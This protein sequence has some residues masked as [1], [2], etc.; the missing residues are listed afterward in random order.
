MSTVALGVPC[1]VI[2][3]RGMTANGLGK[4]IWTLGMEK[5]TQFVLSFYIMEVLYLAEISLIKLSLSLFYLNIFPSA[6]IR[7]LLWGNVIFNIIFGLVFVIG[8][9]FQCTPISFYWTQYTDKLSGGRCFDINGFAWIH[10]ALGV[11][12]DFWMIAIPLS[13][14]RKLELHWKKKIGAIIMFLTGTL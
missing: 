11:A 12:L 5:V 13:Q 1:T 10:A 3:I 7:R 14:V 2:N 4:D 9:I 8:G 6:S